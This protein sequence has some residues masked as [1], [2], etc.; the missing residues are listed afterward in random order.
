MEN[1]DIDSWIQ[2]NADI[3]SNALNRRYGSHGFTATCGDPEHGT[4]ENVLFQPLYP[5][6]M[7]EFDTRQTEDSL[8]DIFMELAEELGIQ[9][10][11]IDIDQQE[12]F[13][14]G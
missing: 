11:D 12:Y 4:P 13:Y 1:E 7:T 6:K 2:C 3:I 8:Y 14:S 9:K 10:E 5:W